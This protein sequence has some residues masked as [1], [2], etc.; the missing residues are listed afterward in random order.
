MAG[1]K[2]NSQCTRRTQAFDHHHSHQR[3]HPFRLGS[4]ALVAHSSDALTLAPSHNQR[5]CAVTGCASIGSSSVVRA[6]FSIC[7]A[8]DRM[9]EK[10]RGPANVVLPK[11][12]PHCSPLNPPSRRYEA[13]LVEGKLGAS[14]II[15][16]NSRCL[17][18]ALLGGIPPSS[19]LLK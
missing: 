6:Q 10:V 14:G 7:K 17:Q 2:T 9:N 8:N 4:R 5:S 1:N 19:P 12:P 16:P 11:P 13:L 18:G 3:P 15:P